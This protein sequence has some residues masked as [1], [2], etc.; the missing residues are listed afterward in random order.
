[1]KNNIFLLRLMVGLLGWWLPADGAVLHAE[2][3]P[4]LAEKISDPFNAQRKTAGLVDHEVKPDN[5]SASID[6]KHKLRFDEV[7]V[8]SL[9]HNPDAKA[10]FFNLMSQTSNYMGTYSA[11]L[12]N[13]TANISRQ[14]ITNYGPNVRSTNTASNYGLSGSLT[15]YDFGQ[16][17]F[18]IDI[19]ELSLAA[20]GMSYNSTLQGMIG[21]ALRG[22]YALLTAQNNLAVV[23]ESEKF[24]KESYDAAMLR[25][26]TGQVP[27][28]DKLQAKASYSGALLASEQAVNQLSQNQAALALLIGQPASTPLEVAEIDKDALN[29]DPFGGKVQALIEQAKQSRLD[30][31]ASRTSLKQ[32]E[33][34]L[35]ATQRADLATISATANMDAGNS[36]ADIF[37][38]NGSHSMGIGIN[39]SIPLFTGFSQLYNERALRE[40]IKAQR[41]TLTKTELTVEQDVW[42]SWHNYE[43]AKLSWKTS[44]DQFAT[45]T[46]LK[47]VTLGRYKEGLGSI[48]D[49]LNAQTQFSSAQQSQ[50]QTRYSLLISRIDLVR[51]VGVLNL[52]TMRPQTTTDIPPITSRE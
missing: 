32:S 30:L 48:L 27:L 43:T 4:W 20:A 47:D 49:V 35:S 21:A 11:Y 38:H 44:Q 6:L 13:V 52:E 22:Y 1:M 33:Q 31:Q 5:C 15:L 46:Q 28:A 25:Y 3:L 10:A 42:N 18:R 45:A 12:P 23:K 34:S 40:S 24:A 41:E 50:L 39:V 51:A 7:V 16:R 36:Q 8:A 14:H 29:N 17:E 9:C 19:A 2:T 26:Q 37:N